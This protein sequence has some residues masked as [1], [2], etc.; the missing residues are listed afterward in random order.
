MTSATPQ[1]SP[2]K[3]TSTAGQVVQMMQAGRSYPQPVTQLDPWLEA[4]LNNIGPDLALE[5]VVLDRTWKPAKNTAFVFET[6]GGETLE[7]P[8]NATIE[9]VCGTNEARLGERCSTR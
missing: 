9:L 4:P 1:P 8:F 2:N 7:T 3:P 5:N 6:N